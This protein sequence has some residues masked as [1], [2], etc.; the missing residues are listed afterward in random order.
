MYIPKH[1][2]K[3]DTKELIEFMR[4]YNFAT[5]I[6]YTKKRYWAT[7]LPFIIA[8]KGNKVI[9]K[10]HMAKKNPQWANFGKE[11]VLIIFQQPL[12]YISPKLYD[13]ETH[14]P[15]WN[16]IAVHAYGV[17]EILPSKSEKI[18]LLEETFG[19]FEKS[20]K[21][22]WDNLPVDYK[23]NLFKNITAF[24]IKI[25]KLEGK[26]KLS[27]NRTENERKKIINHLSQSTE[28]T[29]FDISKFMS[30]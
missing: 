28:K 7:H 4:E 3:K 11:E 16:Y 30:K 13:H 1:F 27:Q 29:I 18:K 2:K 20:F 17:P 6:N 10:S 5:I 25:N 23:N 22:Q 21:E 26:Y 14:V 19:V 8:D 9:L 15:T 12:A 24:K